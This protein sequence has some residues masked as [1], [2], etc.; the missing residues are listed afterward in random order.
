MDYFYQTLAQV[1]IW[2]FRITF[3]ATNMATTCLHLSGHSNL[4]IYPPISS[5]IL[6]LITFIKLWPKFEYGFCPMNDIQ[7]GHLWSFCTCGDSY[8]V[9]CH[10]IF[11]KFL[12]IKLTPKFEYKFCTMKDNK[13]AAKFEYK[14]CTMKDT[15][16]AASCRFAL[17]DTLI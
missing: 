4:V 2:A 1:R 7:N 8:L 16:M 5:K 14:F 10:L 15:K 9:N 6:I 12:A 11:S 13:M 17:V 3:M